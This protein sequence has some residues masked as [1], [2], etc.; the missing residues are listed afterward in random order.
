[1]CV[2]GGGFAGS[3]LAWRLAQLAHVR[4]D[5]VLGPDRG[6]DA[7]SAS[8]G[9]VRAYESLAAQRQLAIASMAEL[10]GS[11][12][13]QRWAN[14]QQGTSVYIRDAAADLPAQVAEIQRELPGSAQTMP[15]AKAFGSTVRGPCWAGPPGLA[16]VERQA[17][18][19][20]PGRL[21]D[22]LIADLAGRPSARLLPAE[23]D[24]V[25]ITAAGP[26]R[27]Q[28]GGTAGTYDI[29]VL[30]VGAWTSG[31]LRAIGVPAEGYRTRSIQ[32]TSYNAGPWRP[33]VFVDASPACTA[34]HWTPAACCS[35][36]PRPSGMWHRAGGR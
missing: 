2:A 24:E 34:S 15:V 14:Y 16:V 21:R 3:L 9:A 18:F 22:A 20:S 30:A 35:A 6:S 26:V 33:P 12:V 10:L 27:I 1:M 29:V 23:L 4:V 25:T 5:L 32:F 11:P 28:A 13:L 8:G 31:V 19:V 17:G 7:T 36:F